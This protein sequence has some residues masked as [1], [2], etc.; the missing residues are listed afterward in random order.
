MFGHVSA[1]WMK[2]L[3]MDFKVSL[4][5]FINVFALFCIIFTIL[6]RTRPSLGQK[7]SRIE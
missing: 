6:E 7:Y 2:G 5:N 1:L 3:N 4:V